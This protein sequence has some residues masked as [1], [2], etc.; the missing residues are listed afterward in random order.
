MLTAVAGNAH[1][2]GAPNADRC[3]GPSLVLAPSLSHR[4]SWTKAAGDARRRVAELSDV[5]VCMRLEVE[6]TRESVHVRASAADGR[7]VVRE[8]TKPSELEA[9]VVA[10]L[11]LP[12]A[13]GDETIDAEPPS[14]DAKASPAAPKTVAS[15]APNRPPLVARART[16]TPA[17]RERELPDQAERGARL[18][19]DSAEHHAFE[20]A[21]AGSGRST[22]Y[23]FGP[24]VSAVADWDLGGWL[25]GGTAHGEQ[26][27]GPSAVAGRFSLERNASV[28]GLIGRRLL[29]RPLLLDVALE[30]PVLAFHSSRWT[31]RSVTSAGSSDSDDLGGVDDDDS[32]QTVSSVRTQTTPPNLDLRVGGFARAIVPFTGHFGAALAADA[33][34]SAGLLPSTSA[35]GQPA[36][37]AWNFGVSLGLFWSGG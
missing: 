1:G 2:Q 26:A 8:V 21:L 9:T 23:L 10:L 35:A 19:A 29:R 20:L 24:G 22:G 25:V 7:S 32:A 17:S 33:E 14:A 37:L 34:R 12:P 3:T 6:A 4:W 30:V 13:A 31:S 36:S 16:R 5:D 18:A 28:G 15:P 27:A 11:V